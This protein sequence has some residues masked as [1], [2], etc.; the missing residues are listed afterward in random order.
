MC[1]Y[2][3]CLTCACDDDGSCVHDVCVYT[4]VFHL[5]LRFPKTTP[6]DVVELSDLCTKHNIIDLYLWLSNRF[7]A[8]FVER[9]QAIA[10]KAF[11]ITLIQ[12]GRLAVIGDVI[13]NSARLA[14]ILI[15]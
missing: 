6:K 8:H 9:E 1:T 15:V 5:P 11:A 3:A 12:Q 10:Q 13:L 7:P 4:H 2:V 14:V